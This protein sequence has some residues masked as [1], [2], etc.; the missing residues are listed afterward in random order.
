MLKLTTN[1]QA[2]LGFTF[3]SNTGKYRRMKT[4]YCQF[5]HNNSSGNLCFNV[6]MTNSLNYNSDDIHISQ[7]SVYISD[8]TMDVRHPHLKLFLLSFSC[9]FVYMYLY[10]RVD[11]NIL[12]LSK[13]VDGTVR[14]LLYLNRVKDK[15]LGLFGYELREGPLMVLFTSWVTKEEKYVCH[16]NTLYNWNAF[17]PSVLPILF[18]NET[19]LAKE[20]VR[21][22]WHVLPITATGT[23]FKLP[24]LR[25]MY[26]A[27]MKRFNATF[28][29][30]ANSDILFTDS[31]LHTLK[32]FQNSSLSSKTPFLIVGRRTNV[33]NVT[34]QEVKTWEQIKNTTLLRGKL[35][36]PWGIDYFIT[37][38]DYPWSIIPD[39][40]IG[41]VAYDN[42][43]VWNARRLGFTTIDATNTLLAMHQTTKAG[44]KE[45]HNQKEKGYNNNVLAKV[46]KNIQYG[47]G[48]VTSTKYFT[49]HETEKESIVFVKRWFYVTIWQS[50]FIL[51]DDLYLH[52]HVTYA[53]E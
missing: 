53:S 11:S 31:L 26:M 42:W 2:S 7:Y 21:K 39:V 10:V 18:T 24:V 8:I 36:N 22:G 20:A 41:R 9:T 28:Y 37:S 25:H 23:S 12:Q 43:M 33:E 49:E 32:A 4:N 34:S 3:H 47:G 17:K 6:L 52:C 14:D 50:S 29:A 13:I 30:Y 46:Y 19:L 1:Q 45:G 15:L 48:L 51:W 35:F 27:V 5:I 38:P 40:V 44:N 16:N